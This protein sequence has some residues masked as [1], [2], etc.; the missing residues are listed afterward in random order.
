VVFR[1]KK[2]MHR[3]ITGDRRGV[4]PVVGFFAFGNNV[5]RELIS[6]VL[7]LLRH[8]VTQTRAT[9]PPLCAAV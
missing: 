1:K 9:R 6:T 8:E 4:L 5:P 3:Q 2:L 7:N